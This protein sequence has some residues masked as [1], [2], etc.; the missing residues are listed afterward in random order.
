M[1]NICFII[2]NWNGYE[3]TVKC[4]ETLFREST[5]F[6]VYLLDNGSLWN[7][8]DLL[9]KTFGN[10]ERLQLFT[11]TTNLGFTGWV[12]LC[13]KEAMKVWYNW[14]CLYNNDAE[15]TPN[16]VQ[17]TISIIS[18]IDDKIGI[19]GPKILFEDQKNIIQSVG[20]K[21]SLWSGICPGIGTG[22][23]NFHE[24]GFIKTDYVS[25]CCFFINHSVIKNIGLLDDRFFAYYEEVDYCIR[26]QNVGFRV[27]VLSQLEIYH[28]QSSSSKKYAGFSTFLM[29][30]N[31]IL[32]LKKHANYL[33]FIVSFLYLISYI[34]FAYIRYGKEN[35]HFLISGTL[36]WIQWKNGDP[37]LSHKKEFFKKI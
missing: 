33:Q 12:N 21:I 14:Y 11:S 31:R 5:D 22:K 37:F 29:F 23:K 25:G 27:G 15:V 9:K 19:F 26:A 10:E 1:N 34:P 13:L 24:T 6:K 32:F 8:F 2:L 3:K 18:K 4:L 35:L 36:E 17:N 16:F 7:D 20:G 28:D 30:R